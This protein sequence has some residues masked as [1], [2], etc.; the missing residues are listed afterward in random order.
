MHLSTLDSRASASGF[1]PELSPDRFLPALTF[2]RYR[3][4]KHVAAE[5]VAEEVKANRLEATTDFA[6]A[7]IPFEVIISDNGSSDGS[8]DYIRHG[9][10]MPTGCHAW[11]KYDRSFWEPHLLTTEYSILQP[12]RTVSLRTR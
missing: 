1:M 5:T 12:K 8:I 4:I 7:K 10:R 9:G 11:T 6:T 3:D 2:V